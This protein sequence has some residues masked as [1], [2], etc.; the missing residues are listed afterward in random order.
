[1]APLAEISPTAH[2]GDGEVHQSQ[3]SADPDAVGATAAGVAEPGAASDSTPASPSAVECGEALASAGSHPPEHAPVFT[4]SSVDSALKATGAASG[5]GTPSDGSPRSERRKSH[6]SRTHTVVQATY[7]GPTSMDAP[8]SST[9]INRH[10]QD[11]AAP[12]NTTGVSVMMCIPRLKGGCIN[13]LP[14]EAVEGADED[15]KPFKVFPV[16]RVIF[17][18]TGV[19]HKTFVGFSMPAP[20]TGASRSSDSSAEPGATSSSPVNVCFECHMVE[21]ASETKA[22]HALKCIGQAFGRPSTS[23]PKPGST[24]THQ[25]QGDKA[26]VD[27]L[28]CV[29]WQNGWFVL[30]RCALSPPMR[31]SRW[32]LAASGGLCVR[33]CRSCAA[34]PWTCAPALPSRTPRVPG[35]TC[36]WPRTPSRSDWTTHD[37]S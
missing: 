26:A 16:H 14:S 20:R 3:A 6:I 31:L 33:S 7:Y 9:E 32:P 35:H 21:F 5:E 13:L 15:I 10:I 24:S 30:C 36:P 23:P 18:A 29:W 27:P 28:Q 19:Q 34:S 1:M 4:P 37:G 17:V 8:S 2:R 25:G 12:E 11:A 22:E